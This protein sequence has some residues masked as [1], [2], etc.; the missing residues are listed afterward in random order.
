MLEPNQAILVTD[1]TS[2]IGRGIIDNLLP[3]GVNVIVPVLLQSEIDKL[4]D[5]YARYNDQIYGVEIAANNYDG[6]V[7]VRDYITDHFQNLDHVIAIHYGW[8]TSQGGICDI[9]SEELMTAFKDKVQKHHDTIRLFYPLLRKSKNPSPSYTIVTSTAGNAVYSLDTCLTTIMTCSLYGLSLALKTEAK[10]KG[11][12]V[13][14]NEFRTDALI[15]I[16]DATT[17]EQNHCIVSNM[18]CGAALVSML[19]SEINGRVIVPKT[20]RDFEK[21]CNRET[22]YEKSDLL[23]QL[24]IS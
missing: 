6:F 1:G 23:N 2:I 22:Y 8:I 10:L 16:Q 4:R 11:E 18:A 5:R 13:R 7:K 12:K 14:V 3:K 21:L 17:E 15:A 19:D 9:S 20:A 24:S